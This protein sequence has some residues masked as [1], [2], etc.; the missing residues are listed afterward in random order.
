MNKKILTI[1][2][3]IMLVP[4]WIFGQDYRSL[5]K[6]VKDAEDKDLPQTAITHLT[7]IEKK[8]RKEGVYGQLL[9]AS[10]YRAQMQA[11]VAPDSLKP[12]V[13]RLVQEAKKEKNVAL[14]AVYATV[15]YRVYK[16][17]QSLVDDAD[18]KERICE[19]Y[20]TIAL[21][22]PEVFGKGEECPLRTF[23]GE[24]E[25]QLYL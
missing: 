25:R 24:R 22:S 7:T 21:S 19:E 4:M 11:E 23:C 8:A 20:R 16:E 13:E 3:I 12:S 2:A 6:Q 1:I 9:K 15:L 5:W 14:R 10:L 17:N 18:A